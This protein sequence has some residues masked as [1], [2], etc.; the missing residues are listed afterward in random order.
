MLKHLFSILLL[1]SLSGKAIG[2]NTL[3]YND[4][5]G[6]PKAT[7]QDVK[8]ISGTWRG[9]AMG[10][11]CEEFWDQPSGNT[12]LF[13]FK[14]LENDKVIFYELG[15][16]I[17]ADNTLFLELKHFGPDLKGW[18]KAD[19]KQ[20]FRLVKQDE[21]RVYF[22]R[23]T[24]EKVSDNEINIYVVFEKSGEEMLFNYKREKS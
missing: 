21:N 24:F 9:E 14:F 16:I 22:D 19:E 6:S 23:F 4:E 11:T 20:T 3:T 5:K 13:C 18:E 1:L 15:H 10:G 12:M 2:Q 8:W 17:E 7:L